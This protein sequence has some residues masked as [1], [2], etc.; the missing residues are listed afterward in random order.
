MNWCFSFGGGCLRVEGAAKKGTIFPY[1]GAPRSENSMLLEGHLRKM[2]TSHGET[3]RY[4]LLL[5][6]QEISLNDLLGSRIRMSFLDKIHCIECG[7]LTKKSWQ[8]GHCYPCTLKLASCDVCIVKPEL[9]HYAKGTCR[10]PKWGEDHC[11]KTHVVYLAN[12]SGAKVGI[13]RETQVPTRWMDQGAV[14]ALPIFKVKTRLD[15]G[16]VEKM[17]GEHVADKTHW[18]RMLKGDPDPIDLRALADSIIDQV[19]EALK[20]HITERLDVPAYNFNYPV[21]K[22]P[23][24]VKSLGLDKNPVLEDKLVG[25]K[26]QYLIFENGVINIR[27]HAGYLVRWEVL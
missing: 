15:S 25:I 6:E 22:Y 5:D 24:K 20:P 17:L 26:G 19:G 27:N 1:N 8:Q 12:S 14:Q 16:L 21:I 7:K 9:C 11:M 13:T 4:G 3:V 23:E 18:Q 10:E 2:R